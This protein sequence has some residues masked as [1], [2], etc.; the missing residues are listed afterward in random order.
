[1]PFSQAQGR[2]AFGPLT[3]HGS[4]LADIAAPLKMICNDFLV[5]KVNFWSYVINIIK[6]V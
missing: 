1:M 4:A 6:A 3:T 2:S 5:V